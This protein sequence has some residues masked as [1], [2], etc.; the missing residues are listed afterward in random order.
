MLFNR[1]IQL[2]QEVPGLDFRGK[3]NFGLAVAALLVL[4]PFSINNF[5]Q[6]RYVL[7]TA[8]VV[9]VAAMASTGWLI[10]QR[11]DPG[12]ITFFVVVPVVLVFLSLS[13]QSQGIVGLLWSYPALV[14]FFVILK[15]RVAPVAGLVLVAVVVPQVWD[16]MG[17]GIG[18]RALSTLIAVGTFTSIFQ[19]ALI[20]SQERLQQLAI[21]D[22]LTGLR[23]RVTLPD[24]LNLAL[25]QYRRSKTPATLLAIDI[26]HFKNI[27]DQLGHAAGDK[28]LTGFAALLTQR[29]RQVDQ[30]FRFGGEEFLVL[31]D[32]T[33]G[34]ESSNIA[35][36]LRSLIADAQL[37]PDR[38]I[39]ASIGVAVL[40]E[41]DS[42]DSWMQ[43][44]DANLYAAK[45][46]G[47]NRVVVD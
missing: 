4:T 8:S 45:Q 10:A 18:W 7:G 16:L 27:N 13:I 22:A 3:A 15:E 33:S 47:R 42:V 26:D 21:T 40:T 19:F 9:I 43:R 17:S 29:F 14:S 20:D 12:P 38:K 25:Q 23:N 36:D 24:A 5:L 31:L 32:H 44:A 39:T 46:A 11:R 34:I 30:I 1:S 37:L 2:L 41:K 6:G 35:E 28:A